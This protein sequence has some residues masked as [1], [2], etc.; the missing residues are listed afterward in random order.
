MLKVSASFGRCWLVIHRSAHSI[1]S[2]VY[3]PRRTSSCVTVTPLRRNSSKYSFLVMSI[4]KQTVQAYRAPPSLRVSCSGVVP[5]CS[6]PFNRGS[7]AVGAIKSVAA[8]SARRRA[9][10]HRRNEGVG[11][12][13]RAY[14]RVRERDGAV[15]SARQLIAGGDQLAA[16]RDRLGRRDEAQRAGGANKRSGCR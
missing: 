8:E 11:A 12:R 9:G 14:H 2:P 16:G 5:I 13:E 7:R 3:S 10:L 1:G 6:H 4:T 15:P